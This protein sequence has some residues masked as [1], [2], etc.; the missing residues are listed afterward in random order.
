MRPPSWGPHREGRPGGLTGGPGVREELHGLRS[1][2]KTGAG[3]EGKSGARRPDG[4][5]RKAGLAEKLTGQRNAATIHRLLKLQAWAVTPEFSD[6]NP[7]GP[8]LAAPVLIDGDVDGRDVIP[9]TVVKAVA[10]GGA[11]PWLAG[12]GGR[13]QLPSGGPGEVRRTCTGAPDTYPSSG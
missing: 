13:G 4:R 3:A 1:W 5:A 7:L 2:W 6:N 9:G 8:L 10:P 11:A 12:F